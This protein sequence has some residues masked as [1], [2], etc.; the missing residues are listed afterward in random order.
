MSRKNQI[1]RMKSKITLP[2]SDKKG[3]TYTIFALNKAKI[4][5][6]KPSVK[7]ILTSIK[8]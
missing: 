8:N 4:N 1:I 7:K 5:A 3:K 2:K 6:I